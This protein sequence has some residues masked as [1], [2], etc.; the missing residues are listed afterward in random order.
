MIDPSR[1]VRDSFQRRS[2]VGSDQVN[3]WDIRTR[4]SEVGT[5]AIIRA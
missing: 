5:I 1:D 2:P 4:R 3:P